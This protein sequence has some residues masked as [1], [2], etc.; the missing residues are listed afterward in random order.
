MALE[1]ALLKRCEK[2][3]RV[4]LNLHNTAVST[5]T[6]GLVSEDG[7]CL[8]P[9]VVTRPGASDELV[10]ELSGP[11]TLPG[12]ARLRCILDTPSG[13]STEEL[14]L[15]PRQG[16]HAY[17]HGDGQIPVE[18]TET[19]VAIS[20]E[21]LCRLS[22][23][24]PWLYRK[25]APSKNCGCPEEELLSML[26]DDFGVELDEEEDEFLKSLRD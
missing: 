8:G 19:G 5:L 7:R 21:A 13:S 26:K 9:A 12:G 6:I 10:V 25:P 11:C 17:L 14:C 2:R 20:K 15:D 16:L 18:S 3:W 4:G 22:A 23:A 1:L 24:L